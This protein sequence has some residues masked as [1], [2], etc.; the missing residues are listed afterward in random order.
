MR[1]TAIRPEACWSDG[2][3]RSAAIFLIGAAAPLAVFSARGLADLLVP[4]ADLHAAMAWLEN[5]GPAWCE[6][7]IAPVPV[8][9]AA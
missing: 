3:G 2:R 7:G 4:C 5:A 6:Q 1:A 8:A 9:A